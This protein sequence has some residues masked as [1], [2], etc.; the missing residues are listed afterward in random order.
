MFKAE[1]FIQQTPQE[2]CE[3]LNEHFESKNIDLNYSLKKCEIQQ[4]M[5]GVSQVRGGVPIMGLACIL[6]EECSEHMAGT[7]SLPSGV[8][9]TI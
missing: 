3:K 7:P 6:I 5:L 4:V 9:G 2:L 8:E 1:L